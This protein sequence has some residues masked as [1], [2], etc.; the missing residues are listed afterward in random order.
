M[1]C[2]WLRVH[3]TATSHDQSAQLSGTLA[4]DQRLVEAGGHNSLLCSG[5]VGGFSS[6]LSIVLCRLCRR[7]CV[8]S[9]SRRGEAGV[10][11]L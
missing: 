2:T 10:M 8:D 4:P 9:D 6:I 11:M 5:V 1:C 7:M 3:V